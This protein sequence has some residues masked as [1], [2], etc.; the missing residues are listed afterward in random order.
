MVSK[1][2]L[3]KVTKGEGLITR[4]KYRKGASGISTKKMEIAKK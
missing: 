2:E 1:D 4:L 3:D